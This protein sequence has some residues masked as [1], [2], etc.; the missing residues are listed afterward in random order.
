[1]ITRKKG[2]HLFII[3]ALIL[4]VINVKTLL[5][6]IFPIAYENHILEYSTKYNI[7]PYLVTA[8]INIESKFNERALSAKGA[9]GLMQIM[10]DTGEWISKYVGIKTFSYDILYDPEINIKMG[11]WYINNLSKEFDGELDL[12]LAAYNGGRG[13]VN[14]WLANK[15]YSNNG[16]KLTKIPFKETNDYLKKVKF[17][18][19]V[20]KLLYKLNDQ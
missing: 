10:P 18:Y 7:D 11:C 9:Y 14:K 4:I 15:E 19:K 13:N 16:K 1:M 8:I 6:F 2:L 3:I 12:I 17:S 20:Y 5:R